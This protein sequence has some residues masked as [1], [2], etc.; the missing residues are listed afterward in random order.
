MEVKGN[1]PLSESPT[2]RLFVQ[3]GDAITGVRYTSEDNSTSLPRYHYLTGKL[4]MELLLLGLPTTVRYEIRNLLDQPYEILPRY[5]MPLLNHSIS[6]SIQ[7][8]L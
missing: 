1:V 2:T 3:V 5:P 4:G 6:L 8:L 7:K